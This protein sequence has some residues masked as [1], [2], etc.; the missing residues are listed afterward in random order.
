MSTSGVKRELDST[1]ITP[2]ALLEGDD[3]DEPAFVA[4]SDN[5]ALDDELA[6]TEILEIAAAAQEEQQQ[7]LAK[8]AKAP[9]TA[10]AVAPPHTLGG[11]LAYRA[12]RDALAV[13]LARR[14]FDGLRQSALWLVTELTADFLKALGTQLQREAAMPRASMLPALPASSIA[15]PSLT[16]YPYASIAVVKQL[17]RHANMQSLAEWRQAAATFTRVAEPAGVQALGRLPPEA[18]HSLPAPPAVAPLYLAMKGVWN[19]KVT[20]TGRAAHSA[21]AIQEFPSAASAPLQQGASGKDLSESLRL[22]KKQ[23]QLAEAWLQAATGATHT[24]PVLLPGPPLDDNGNRVNGG[25]AGGGDGMG[26]APGGKG[27]VA[28]RGRKGK[29]Q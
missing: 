3:D 16:P 24:A 15:N 20:G 10:W 14:G 25:G 17:Q 19:Y 5:P 11:P 4:A 6:S 23:R 13:Q 8:L 28:P 22:S 21:A 1:S 29:Q 18:R 9:P 2:F 27:K 26:G 12:M 7:Q